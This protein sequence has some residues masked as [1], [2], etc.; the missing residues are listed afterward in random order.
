MTT[1]NRANLRIKPK[2]PE[3]LVPGVK[4]N[5]EPERKLLTQDKLLEAERIAQE[6]GIKVTYKPAKGPIII[7]NKNTVAYP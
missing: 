2:M 7:F 5:Q 1:E 4:L 6:L 3:S